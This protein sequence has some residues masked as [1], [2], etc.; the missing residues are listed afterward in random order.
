MIYKPNTWDF[1]E[2]ELQRDVDLITALVEEP[3][4]NAE[5]FA[6]QP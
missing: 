4:D 1:R 6:R 3:G 2:E 5:V